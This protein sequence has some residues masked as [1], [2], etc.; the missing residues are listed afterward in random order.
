[1]FTQTDPSHKF[2]VSGYGFINHER[3][4]NSNSQFEVGFNPIF[5]WSINNEILFEGEL[6][7]ELEENSTAM[8]LEYAHVVYVANK[9]L[10]FGAGKFL[11]PNNVFSERYHPAWINKLPDMPLGFSGHSSVQLVSGNQIGA[12][13]RGG[14]PVE[15]V[16]IVYAVY[17]SNGPALNVEEEMPDSNSLMKYNSSN[18]KNAINDEGEGNHGAAATGTLSFGNIPDNNK[19]KA[20][21]GRIGFLP[22]PELEIGYGFE[23][24]RVGTD[25]T[26]FS[27]VGYFNNIIDFSYIQ[28]LKS[29][30]GRI[31][32]RGQFTSLNIDNPGIDHLD[33]DNKS[34]AWYAQL[35]YQP[36]YIENSFLKNIEIVARYDQID[37]PEG[38]EL[39]V[40]QKR[41]TVGLNYWLS[42]STVF[43]FA[44]ENTTSEHEDK[45]ESESS[46]IFQMAMGF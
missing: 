12:Q 11:S 39:N 26:E 42:H 31:D 3:E 15:S 28:D 7:L 33:Y 29:L 38:A 9:Y 32:L 10:T 44:Y 6:E 5:L 17:I 16:K 23:S 8:A 13:V 14:I 35:A 1:M 2:L 46:F 45:S 40:D 24:A 22:V 19:N 21:G 4:E 30:A 34:N 37:L 20:V 18:F 27:D 43:K 41:I 25:D 36:Y